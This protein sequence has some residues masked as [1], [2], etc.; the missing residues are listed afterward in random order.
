MIRKHI[1]LI[2]ILS[3]S[4]LALVG[5]GQTP[6]ANVSTSSSGVSTFKVGKSRLM[7]NLVA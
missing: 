3:F 4:F 6:T 5:C 2:Y 7:I 1:P